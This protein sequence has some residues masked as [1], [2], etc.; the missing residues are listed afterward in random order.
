MTRQFISTNVFDKRWNELNL[1]DE[2]LRRLENYLMRN[3]GYGDIIPGTGGAIKLR[4]SLPN[5]GKRGGM[6]IIYIDLIIAEQVH[7]LTCYPKSKKDSLT[8]KEK[9][10]IKETVKRIN[11]NEGMD[12]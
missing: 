7:F 1:T 2:D 9:A 11:K 8:D 6:R 10:Q 12:L 4:W 5:T 3:P